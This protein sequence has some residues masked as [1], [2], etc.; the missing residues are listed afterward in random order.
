M[1]SIY[2]CEFHSD[3]PGF[4]IS[5]PDVPG[6]LTGDDTEEG[7]RAGAMDCL[8]TA[9]EAC[10]DLREE[11]PMPSQPKEGQETIILP[12]LIAAKLA[13]Y[14]GMR[15]LRM[16]NVAMGSKLGL[17]ETVVRRMLDLRHRSHIG[18]VENALAILGKRLVVSI[19]DAA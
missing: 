5:F 15:I 8:I 10:I 16:T 14:E 2:P 4:Y 13:L 17:S 6:A 3:P 18:Q 9:L 12:P 1:N 11:I 19:Q 7:T